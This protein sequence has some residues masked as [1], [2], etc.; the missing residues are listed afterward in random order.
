MYLQQGDVLLRRIEGVPKKALCQ[1]HK[2][3][4]EGESTGHRHEVFGLADLYAL[5]E[6]L[7]LEV[8]G[9]AELRHQEHLPITLP[10]GTYA[11]GIVREYDH[12]AEEARRVVD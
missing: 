10:P 2:V 3:L 7:Y 6:Q 4:A 8:T 12:F 9:E 11:V 1:D 5:D